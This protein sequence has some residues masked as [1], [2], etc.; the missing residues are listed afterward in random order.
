[1]SGLGGLKAVVN[2]IS[3]SENVIEIFKN[4]LNQLL[5]FY[6]GGPHLFQ[7]LVLLIIILGVWIS[8]Y[9]H[10][11]SGAFSLYQ[12]WLI[13]FPFLVVLFFKQRMFDRTWIYLAVS[14]TWAISYFFSVINNRLAITALAIIISISQF[15]V[16][17]ENKYFKEQEYQILAVKR[18]T[19]LAIK[20]NFK[21]IFIDHRFLRPMI[22]YNLFNRQN[23][24]KLSIKGSPFNPIEFDS[25][26]G[27][28]MIVC[29]DE[30]K[31]PLPHGKYIISDSINELRVLRFMPKQ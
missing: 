22:E 12:L 31:L 5:D 27:Y 26:K 17:H 18:A 24:I 20:E 29:T 3:T 10:R 2:G 19:D 11:K 6:I 15:I 28:D 25:S 7:Y 23:D 13:L 9:L 1:M 14:F 8:F 30:S 16:S 4:G 21:H